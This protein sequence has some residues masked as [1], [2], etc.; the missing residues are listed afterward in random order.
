LI[1]HGKTRGECLMR[2]RRALDEIVV[3]GI[4]TT[5]PLFRALVREPD[6]ADGNYHIHWLERFLA[7]GG[8]RGEAP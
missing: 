4:E 2:L 3:D 6:I 8:M 5:L 1:V 7:E